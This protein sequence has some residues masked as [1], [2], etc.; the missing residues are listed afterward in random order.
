MKIGDTVRSKDGSTYGIVNYSSFGFSIHFYDEENNRMG[1]TLGNLKH[2][3][4]QH[5]DV[6]DMPDGYEIA[7]YG[8]IRKKK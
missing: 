8:L 4:L 2:E 1:K 6:C 7:E 3:V 5:W